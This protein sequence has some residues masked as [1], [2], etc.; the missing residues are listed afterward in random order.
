MPVPSDY[1]TPE[2]TSAKSRA[3]TQLRD[4]I[5]DGTLLPGEK[6]LD[7]ELAAALGLSRTPVREAL[8]LLCSQ[9]FVDMR[10]SRETVVTDAQP[11]RLALLLPPLG[12][13]ERLAAEIAARAQDPE[14]LGELRQ[15]NGVFSRHVL[16][17][18]YAAA[19]QYDESFHL[20]LARG[21]GNPYLLD[22]VDTLQ[23]HVRRYFAQGIL[24]LTERSIHE[25][26]RVLEAIRAGDAEI[27]G[28]VMMQ[29]FQRP[30]DEILAKLK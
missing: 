9:G 24:P 4:W 14:L 23:A 17:K 27:A 20:T 30:L 1:L 2:K 10:P 22:M 18:S 8:Q 13:M 6:I 21:S 5:I 3:Y 12:A 19:L 11:E 29:N 7:A 28:A 15:I 16:N 26:A 25:H